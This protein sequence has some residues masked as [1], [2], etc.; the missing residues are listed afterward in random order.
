MESVRSGRWKLVS[1]HDGPWQLFDLD[2]D[3]S[4]RTDLTAK[5]LERVKELA[6]R[7]EAWGKCCGVEPWPV[8]RT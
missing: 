6:A 5:E 2:A 3:R 1:A 8:V 4:E 7:D